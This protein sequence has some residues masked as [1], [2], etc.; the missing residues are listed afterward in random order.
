MKEFDPDAHLILQTT[1]GERIMHRENSAMYTFLG[2]LAMYDHIFV[3]NEEESDED[4]SLG[5]YIFQHNP[6][7][8]T[9]AHYM[10]KESFPMHLNMNEVAECDS[11]AFDRSIHQEAENDGDFLPPDWEDGSE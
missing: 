9:L 2:H 5:M 7:F 4:T 8:T 3:V 10:V 11:D 6:I 1:D